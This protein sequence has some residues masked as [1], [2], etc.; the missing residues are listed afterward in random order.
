V[1]GKPETFSTTPPTSELYKA[2][3]NIAGTYIPQPLGDQF[4][5]ASCGIMPLR[6]THADY[7]YGEIPCTRKM[8]EAENSRRIRKRN[9]LVIK[10][11]S[12]QDP[13]AIPAVLVHSHDPFHGRPIP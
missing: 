7:F 13:D 1:E 9:R 2:F 3:P 10:E 6:T 5:T 12:R 4:C 8:T 11:P